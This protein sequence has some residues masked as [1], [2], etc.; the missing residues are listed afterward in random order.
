MKSSFFQWI[1]ILI[2]FTWKIVFRIKTKI[3]VFES[4]TAFRTPFNIGS[5]EP[6]F[7]ALNGF[8]IFEVGFINLTQTVCVQTNIPNR[9]LL[10]N[11]LVPLNYFLERVELTKSK[12]ALCDHRLTVLFHFW[13]LSLT[14]LEIGTVWFFRRKH[15]L[16]RDFW[17]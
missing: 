5:V 3:L 17:F 1:A 6:F 4:S 2:L 15:V 14:F 13:F 12:I 9:Q 16:W 11:R 10:T 8:R 7:F